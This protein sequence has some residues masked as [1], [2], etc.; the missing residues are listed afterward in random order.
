MKVFT[1]IMAISFA[2]LILISLASCG[3]VRCTT[4]ASNSNVFN[5]R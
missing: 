1:S 2:L 5:Y 3:T 4:K